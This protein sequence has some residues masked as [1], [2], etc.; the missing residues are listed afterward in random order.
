VGLRVLFGMLSLP[1]LVFAGLCLALS[2]SYMQAGGRVAIRGVLLFGK[3]FISI[4][5]GV[6]GGSVMID[7]LRICR[8]LV[9]NSSIFSF[10]FFSPGQQVG[11]PCG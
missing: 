10:L 9:R 6:Y 2:R 3:W 7:V 11:L 1:D 5:C 8:G 4:L